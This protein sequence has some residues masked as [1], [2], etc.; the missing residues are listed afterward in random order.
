VLYNRFQLSTYAFV[1]GGL[2]LQGNWLMMHVRCM[3]NG[4][5]S[6]H[7]RYWT[8]YVVQLQLYP[9]CEH[10][11]WYR[12]NHVLSVYDISA[13]GGHDPHTLCVEV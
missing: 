3:L 12:Y 10:N 1:F 2:A 6:M 8:L 4:T 7:S 13:A 9:F 11:M 5:Y